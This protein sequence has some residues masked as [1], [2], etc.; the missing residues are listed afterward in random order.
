[1]QDRR[2]GRRWWVNLG[3]SA[4]LAVLIFVTGACGFAGTEPNLPETLERYEFLQ[5]RMGIPVN[6]TLY[7]S[8]PAIANQAAEAA[9]A[10]FRDL[11]RV[12]SDYDPD[13]EL[14]RLCRTAKVGEPIPVSEDLLEVLTS[15]QDLSRRTEGAFDVTVG[16]VVK[17]WR[18]ARRRKELPEPDR[19]GEARKLVGYESLI[20]DSEQRTVTLLKAKM[21]LDLGAIAKGYA[22]DAAVRAMQEF[23]V[24]RVLVDA[25]GDMVAGDPPPGREYWIIEVEKLRPRDKTDQPLPR[26]Q[27]ANGGVATSGD[28]Y[29]YLEID[30]TRY[31]HIVD[32]STGLGLTTPSTVTVIAKTAMQADALASAISV[33]SKRADIQNLC[34]DHDAQSLKVT[35][36]GDQIAEE[37]TP[38][39]AKYWVE[40]Q[41]R[42]VESD[43]MAK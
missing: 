29:Q 32:P 42:N 34:T 21:Q 31:S 41:Q 33:L 27:I 17:L 36:Q 30:G 25:G 14:M 24:T 11:D 12:M 10:R 40:S 26:L 4:V 9:Y 20:V 28:A 15:A 7:A 22:A 38:G 2:H 39:F 19:L 35:L 37:A 3:P 6:I 43:A 23:G 8:S 1:M 18:I 13:S 5:I 16:P